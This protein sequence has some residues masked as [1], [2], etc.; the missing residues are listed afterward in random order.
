MTLSE[1][2][3]ALRLLPAFA[4]SDLSALEPLTDEHVQ[5]F[6]TENAEVW[7]D[8]EELFA[9]LDQMRLLRLRA[10]WTGDL[11]TGP[12]WAAGTAIYTLPEGA[13]L[14]TRVSFVF[15]GGR[16]VHGHFSAPG[17]PAT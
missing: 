3:L 10:E 12:G 15:H 11:R 9:A 6:G 17:D 8:R 5:V 7:S 14:T 16:L 13:T 1:D 4:R 2:E